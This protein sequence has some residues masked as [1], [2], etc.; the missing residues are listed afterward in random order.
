LDT[1]AP[2]LRTVG[3]QHI[4][5]YGADFVVKKGSANIALE[6]RP[7]SIVLQAGR[8]V[9]GEIAE[10][11]R[12]S[13][14]CETVPLQDILHVI[15]EYTQAHMVAGKRIEMEQ[16]LETDATVRFFFFRII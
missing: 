16:K 15:P 1:Q 12:A 14:H 10:Q 13:G 4:S 9:S 8:Y 5:R 3:I 7:S 11:W 6:G 2:N